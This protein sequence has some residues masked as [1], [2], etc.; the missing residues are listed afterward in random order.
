MYCS[1]S[2]IGAIVMTPLLTKLLAGQLVPVDSAVS[3]SLADFIQTTSAFILSY[4][5]NGYFLELPTLEGMVV[6]LS[7]QG[8]AISTFQ[9][10]LL[11]TIIG[12]KLKN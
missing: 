6:L 1:C 11:P 4:E 7:L 10:V 3:F 2:T 5:T 9:V 8:L 12:G